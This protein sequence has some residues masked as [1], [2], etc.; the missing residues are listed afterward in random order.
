MIKIPKKEKV[1]ELYPTPFKHHALA[2]VFIDNPITLQAL[3]K[4]PAFADIS[5]KDCSFQETVHAMLH[6]ENF[7]T[8]AYIFVQHHSIAIFRAFHPCCKIS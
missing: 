7:R 5:R 2:R 4:M 6:T 3:L 8:E 1:G